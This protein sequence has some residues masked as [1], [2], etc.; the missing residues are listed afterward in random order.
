M[1]AVRYVV[2]RTDRNSGQFSVTHQKKQ[3]AIDEAK[4][5]A[6]AHA[7]EKPEFTVYELKAVSKIIPGMTLVHIP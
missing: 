2:K 3:D 5:L 4:R 6:E 7:K 1:A